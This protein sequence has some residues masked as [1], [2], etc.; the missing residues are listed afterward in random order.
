MNDKV[1][2]NAIGDA[3]ERIVE[4]IDKYV[5]LTKR[6][7]EYVACCPFHDEKSP[8]FTVNEKKL[9]YYCFGCGASGDTMDFVQKYEG[10]TFREAVLRINGKL[11]TESGNA[12]VKA[13]ARVVEDPEWVP[14]TPVPAGIKQRP[15]N[16]FNRRGKDGNWERMTEDSRYSY[17]DSEGRLLGYV[18][19]FNLPNEGKETVPQTFCENTKTGEHSWRWLSFSKPRPMYGLHKLALYPDAQVMVV[20]GEKTAD[21]GQQKFIDAGVPLEKLIVVSW[22]GGGKAVKYTDFSPL[23]GRRAGLWPDADLQRYVNEHPL[24]GQVMPFLE[25]PGTKAML[26]IYDIL[27]SHCDPIKFIVPPAD[28]PN[29]WDIA[30]DFPAGLTIMQHIKAAT[31]MAEDVRERFAPAAEAAVEDSAMPEPIPLPTVEDVPWEGESQ[32]GGD[33]APAKLEEPAVDDEFE[34]LANN[35]YFTILGY[36]ECTYYLFSFAK[37]QVMS[38]TKG[39][40][41]DIGLLEIAP[42]NFWEMNF[43]G[44]EKSVNRKRVAE[45]IFGVAHARGIYDPSRIRGR[46]AWHDAG[47]HVFHHGDRLTVDG[48]EVHLSRIKSGYVYP[49]A[50]ALPPLSDTPLTDAEGEYLL[51]VARMARWSMPASAALIIGFVML[52]PICGAL[53]WRPHLWLTGAAGSGKS[54]LLNDFLASLLANI[55]VLAQGNSTEAGIRQSLKADALPVLIDELEANNERERL[56]VEN[57]LSMIRQSSSE[58]QAQTLKGTVSGDSMNFHIRSMFCLASINTSLDKKADIDR[59]TKLSLLQPSASGLDQWDKLKEALHLISTD[60]TYPARLMARAVNMLP[61]IHHNIAVF[62]KAAA[63][64]FGSQRDGDQFGTLMAGAWSLISSKPVNEVQALATINKFE[65]KEHI[66]DHGQDDAMRALERVLSS[67]IRIGGIINEVTVYELIRETSMLHRTGLL[68]AVAAD[69]ILRRNGMCVSAQHN[70]AVFGVS[71]TPLKELVKDADFATDL[72]GQLLRVPGATRYA[73][74]WSFNG[75]KGRVVM[76]PLDTILGAPRDDGESPI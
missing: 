54:T 57:I 55:A 49:R 67:K 17:L 27:A 38:V 36:N 23:F 15:M 11:D 24:A 30:D 58:S 43:P 6:G 18:C 37:L 70:C 62:V 19:R 46:G 73:T 9:M 52:A 4:I 76:I 25:Q 1:S 60:T 51:S 59:L 66:E 3:K 40:I 42:A 32:F 35:G 74:T 21:M 10:L 20:E 13:R 31:M 34:E 33:A 8:S 29:G 47:R 75:A 71:T 41:S 53:K 5:P 61:I 68:D 22:A 2:S 26:E 50:R 12:P 69:N 63:K 14:V 39:D 56:R 64:H 65:W 44:S 45:W 28:V 72:R 48:V 7:A 16:V